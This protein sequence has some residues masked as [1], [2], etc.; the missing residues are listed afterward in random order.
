MTYAIVLMYKPAGLA[1]VVYR[2]AESEDGLGDLR[3]FYDEHQ[4]PA[5]Y[6]GDTDLLRLTNDRIDWDPH[7]LFKY[8][9]HCVVEIDHCGLTNESQE[10]IEKICTSGLGYGSMAHE[11]GE[12]TV[13]PPKPHES[14]KPCPF[15]G[16]TTLA[17]FDAEFIGDCEVQCDGCGIV[18]P[19][20]DTRVGAIN[21]WNDR[22]KPFVKRF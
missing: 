13:G 15:C 10:K 16:S 9:G 8:V 20:A 19:S 4:C 14:L 5:N 18:G 11:E 22:N 3:Y 6:L 2:D 12:C 1:F 21:R 7:G 17:V